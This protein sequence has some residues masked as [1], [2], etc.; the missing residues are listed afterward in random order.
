LFNSTVR[1]EQG[2][3]TELLPFT[4]MDAALNIGVVEAIPRHLHLQVLKNIYKT[5]RPGGLL[6]LEDY[7]FGRHYNDFDP[8]MKEE[9]VAYDHIQNLP[10]YWSFRQ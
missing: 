10:Y 7:S 5:L 1:F 2:D 6:Y 9:F 3:A 4:G 8:K